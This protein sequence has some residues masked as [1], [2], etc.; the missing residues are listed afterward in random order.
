MI[1]IK[2]FVLSILFIILLTDCSA[3]STV[4]CEGK[5]EIQYEKTTSKTKKDGYESDTK[6]EAVAVEFLNHFN[7]KIKGYVNG[8]L[9]FDNTVVTDDVTGIS[10]QSFGYNYSNDGD[11]PT[12]KLDVEGVGCFEVEVS[13]KYKLI[14]VFLTSENKIIVRYSNTIYEAE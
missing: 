10:G 11:L 12:I 13:K 3:Q 2:D 14:Y 7:H 8:D 4:K 1:I 5:Y 9:V 6:L